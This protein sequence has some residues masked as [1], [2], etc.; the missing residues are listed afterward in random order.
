M[1]MHKHFMGKMTKLI[2]HS[3]ISPH[4]AVKTKGKSP[5]SQ[6]TSTSSINYAG[7]PL[8][9]GLLKTAA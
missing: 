3:Q 1:L 7:A 6:L 4:A 5:V 2:S 9:Y 8:V